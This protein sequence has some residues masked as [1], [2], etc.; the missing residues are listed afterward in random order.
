MQ[1]KGS[2][3]LKADLP[4]ESYKAWII[5]NLVVTYYLLSDVGL[6]VRPR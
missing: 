1:T 5:S 3:L 6:C 4:D 2:L